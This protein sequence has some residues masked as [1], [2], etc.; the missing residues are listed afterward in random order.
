MSD[1]M[2]FGGMSAVGFRVETRQ[3]FIGG[4]WV[5]LKVSTTSAFR[6]P[7]LSGQFVASVGAEEQQFPIF[8][9]A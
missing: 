5:R 3:E 1:A 8:R 2:A 7:K 9:P 4:S 6:Y